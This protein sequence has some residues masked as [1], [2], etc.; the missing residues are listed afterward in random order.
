MDDGARMLWT[1]RSGE[2]SASAREGADDR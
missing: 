1:I 2:R